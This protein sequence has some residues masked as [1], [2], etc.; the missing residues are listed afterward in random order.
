MEHRK[1]LM[2]GVIA[3]QRMAAQ[4]KSVKPAQ[5]KMQDPVSTLGAD[6]EKKNQ[7]DKSCVGNK[8]D[9]SYKGQICYIFYKKAQLQTHE[10]K[11]VC[12]HDNLV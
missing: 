2:D 9:N 6:S 10:D 7:P 3:P 11:S 5:K 1:L 12:Y 8:A 4:M